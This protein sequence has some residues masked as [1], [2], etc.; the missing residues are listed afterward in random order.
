MLSFF[1]KPGSVRARIAPSPTG[2][3]HLGTAR[4]ALF[5]YLFAKK[6][7]GK[8]ILRIEDTDLER[9]DKK[10]EKD[11]IENLK[12]L[13]IEWDE[14]P[15]IGGEYAPYRQSERTGIYSKYIAKLLEDGATPTGRQAAFYCFHSEEELET[16]RKSLLEKKESPK[17][18]CAH[19][20]LAEEKK[21]ELMAKGNYVIRFRPP[22]KIVT[23]EDLIRG[24]IEFDSSLMGDISIAKELS[25]PLYNFAVVVDDYEMKI[26]FVIRGEDH[27]SNTPKQILLQEALG[28]PV[29]VYAHLP[30]ILNPDRTKL[31]KRFA[32]T[33]IVDYKNDGFL[34]EVLVNFI[35]LLGWNPGTDEDFFALAD[36]EKKFSLERV[37][38]SGAVF[39]LEKLEWLNG[40]YIRQKD[41][42]ELVKLCLPYFGREAD[43]EYAKKIVSLERERM[44]KLSDIKAAAELFFAEE[45]EYEK[46]LLRWKKIDDEKIKTNLTAA[47]EI[48]GKINDSDFSA[49]NIKSG[50]D[51]KAK[52]TG[53]GE[54]FWPLRVALSGR[55]FSPPPQ[56]IAA[57]LGKEKSLKRIDEAL[58][59]V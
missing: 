46:E 53:T 40:H 23:F 42:D 16:E 12:W 48:L 29:P 10:Y 7:G 35:A 8:F 43:F 24:K 31:S 47:K 11:I 52:E 4:T 57:I 20:G 37:Q 41:L 25:V 34:P 1:I 2:W 59:K 51:E 32:Q 18:V 6:H 5:N 22:K 38:K 50:L 55:K 19:F 14:G 54:L 15:D 9:S 36:L 27:I 33:S 58:K 13:G 49:G 21:R 44:K 26:N 28:F 56:D 30:L 17:H 3:L 39:N 45:L